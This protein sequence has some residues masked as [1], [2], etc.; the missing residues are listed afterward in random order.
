MSERDIST[1]VS[2]DEPEIRIPIRPGSTMSFEGYTPKQ[3]YYIL[4]GYAVYNPVTFDLMCNEASSGQINT[5]GFQDIKVVAYGKNTTQNTVGESIKLSSEIT[6]MYFDGSG[7]APYLNVISNTYTFKKLKA[8]HLIALEKLGFISGNRNVIKPDKT[9]ERTAYINDMGSV[10]IKEYFL[11][12]EYY[13]ICGL[14]SI[15]R[16]ALFPQTA[17]NNKF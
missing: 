8:K 11:C 13:I 16:S 2:T 4:E 9:D 5:L 15:N 10:I 7:N 3:D 6:T 17:I 14:P 12:R 1:K